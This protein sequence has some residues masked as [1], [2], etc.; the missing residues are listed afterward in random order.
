MKSEG[1]MEIIT[2]AGR[3]AGCLKIRYAVFVDEQGV[4]FELEKDGYDDDGAPCEHYL[5]TESGK[6]V[7]TFRVIL[8]E[9]S[10]AHI[11]RFCVLPEYRKKGYGAAALAF[12]QKEYAARGYEKLVLGAQCHAVPFY[13]KCGF[14]VVSDVYDDA[15]IPHRDMEK[16]L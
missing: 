8:D 15:G 4:P 1:I 13:E 11:G 12:A 16:K 14:N 7:G 9:G 2:A 5:I 6:C 10:A 3:K